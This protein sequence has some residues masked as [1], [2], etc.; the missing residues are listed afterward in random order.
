MSSYPVSRIGRDWVTITGTE[1]SRT[2]LSASPRDELHALQTMGSHDDQVG[3]HFHRHIVNVVEEVSN[4]NRRLDNAFERRQLLF[5]KGPSRWRAS[6]KLFFGHDVKQVQFTV[7]CL[8]H[9]KRVV[10]G[11]GGHGSEVHRD[12][13]AVL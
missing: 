7:Q 10:D 11:V 9:S 2:I 13:N 4:A 1:H 12:Q 6:A 3:I 8:A 5:G